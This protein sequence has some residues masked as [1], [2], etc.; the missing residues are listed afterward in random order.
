LEELNSVR[1]FGFARNVSETEHGVYTVATPL[2]D[3]SG[4]T[5]AALAVS[6]P[7]ARLGAPTDGPYAFA[8][9]GDLLREARLCADG[10]R[11]RLLDG[12]AP[13]ARA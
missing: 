8:R 13:A 9:E 7:L 12:T 11:A 2:C 1:R 4:M 6:A 5:I 10:I 3:G